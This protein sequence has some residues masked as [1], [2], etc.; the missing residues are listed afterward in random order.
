MAYDRIKDLIPKGAAHE[1]AEVKKMIPLKKM[2]KK[3]ANKKSSPKV[4]LTG[5]NFVG[6]REVR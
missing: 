1:T 6:S 5:E 4:D 3:P 2:S